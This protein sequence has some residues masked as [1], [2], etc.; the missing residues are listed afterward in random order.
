MRLSA[1]VSGGK[2]SIFSAYLCESHGWPVEELLTLYPADR[3]S[4]LFHT[5]NLSV[6]P[7]LAQA[8]GKRHV[9][10]EVRGTGEEPELQALVEAF[11]GVRQ[12]GFDGV[13]VGAIHSSYQWS[14]V[15]HAAHIA[16]LEV[17]APLWR[18]AQPEILREICAAGI[19]ARI[20]SVA[21]EPLTE[22]LLGQRIDAGMIERFR[23]LS[24]RVREFNI[25]GEGGE[26]E[27]LVVDAPFLRARVEVD[28]SH[29]YRSGH[30]ATLVIDTARLEDHPAR[31]A[32][33]EPGTP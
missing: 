13:V 6:V 17:F 23:T 24:G 12:R 26:Y 18:A 15:W 4:M 3:D 8:W 28:T 14:R 9:H 29:V 25:A 11:N 20:T 10:A 31:R 22:E 32:V 5:P 19:D 7:L 33:R 27:S 21:S 16:G 1:L 30:Q 2:D